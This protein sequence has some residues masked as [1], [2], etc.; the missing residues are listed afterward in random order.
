VSIGVDGITMHVKLLTVRCSADKCVKEDATVGLRMWCISDVLWAMLST[1]IVLIDS[2]TNCTSESMLGPV[3]CLGAHESGKVICASI[4]RAT[5][6]AYIGV[7]S[8]IIHVSV[9]R[10]MYCIVF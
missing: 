10:Q 2:G 7:D 3:L 1:C 6:S 4:E 5:C 8:V 9:N